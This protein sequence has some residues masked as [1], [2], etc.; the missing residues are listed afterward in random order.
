MK[1]YSDSELAVS[2]IQIRMTKYP[3]WE[4]LRAYLV[5]YLCVLVPILLFFWL[6]KVDIVFF[7]FLFGLWVGALIRDLGWLIYTKQTWSFQEKI[8]DWQ[9]VEQ[10]MKLNVDTK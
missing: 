5:K 7:I 9:K 2:L 6:V 4:Y 8:T 1:K 3:L 10:L